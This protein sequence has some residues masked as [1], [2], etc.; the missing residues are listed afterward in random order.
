M[1]NKPDMGPAQT[2]AP[3]SSTILNAAAAPNTTAAPG[4]IV[5]PASGDAKVAMS[6]PAPHAD[7]AADAPKTDAPKTDAPKSGE[8]VAA[9]AVADAAKKM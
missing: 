2:N 8:H 3:A 1:T 6:A 9:P 7:K 4:T 5:P